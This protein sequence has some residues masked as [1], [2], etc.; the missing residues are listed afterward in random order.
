MNT[1]LAIMN[2]ITLLKSRGR[3]NGRIIAKLERRLRQIR[4]K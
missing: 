1:E 3:D 4:G 2:R